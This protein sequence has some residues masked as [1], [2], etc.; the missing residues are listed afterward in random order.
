MNSVLVN[1][2]K[3]LENSEH[4]I[5]KKIWAFAEEE[6]EYEVYLKYVNDNEEEDNETDEK[7]NSFQAMLNSIRD[8]NVDYGG[9]EQIYD[10]EMQ[11]SIPR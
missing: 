6:A 10:T 1:L 9:A 3:K 7:E 4:A 2:N 5:S 11:C 8:E